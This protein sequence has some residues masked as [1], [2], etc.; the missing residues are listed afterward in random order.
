VRPLHRIRSL[1]KQAPRSNGKPAWHAVNAAAPGRIASGPS[2]VSKEKN[3]SV[4]FPI[5][6][7][8]DQVRAAIVGRDEFIVADKGGY[9]VANYIFAGG[10][11]TFGCL[12]TATPEE[13]AKALLRREARGMKFDMSGKPVARPYHKFFNFGEKFETLPANVDFSIAHH[14]LDKLDGSMIHPAPVDGMTRLMT[15]MGITHVSLMAEDFV[16]NGSSLHYAEFCRDLF[17][18]GMTPILEFCSRK[19]RIVIDYPVDQLILTGIRNIATG[20]YVS[21]VDMVRIGGDYGIR[22]S[23]RRLRSCKSRSLMHRSD[24]RPHRQRLSFHSEAHDRE[25]QA[26]Q[27]RPIFRARPPARSIGAPAR[28]AGSGRGRGCVGRRGRR[29]EGGA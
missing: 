28:G 25:A 22:Y 4:E 17:A 23:R 5:I 14:I 10:P 19:Q 11:E 24:R 18:E 16:L 1:I 3:M 6:T 29:C 20:R 27:V 7:H 26:G 12:L 21:Y 9:F 2:Q 8:L 15:R 13:V